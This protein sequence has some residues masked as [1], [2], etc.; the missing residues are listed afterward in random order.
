MSFLCYET[1]RKS[2]YY[3]PDSVGTVVSFKRGRTLWVLLWVGLVFRD[4]LYCLGR[5]AGGSP[6]PL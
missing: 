3:S 5:W 6:R 4:L 1:D 2:G